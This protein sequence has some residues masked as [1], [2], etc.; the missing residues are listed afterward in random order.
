MWASSVVVVNEGLENASQMV[1]VE[2]QEMVQTLFAHGGHPPF[3][4]GIGV[5]RLEGN[6]N[7]ADT[8]LRDLEP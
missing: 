8:G 2:D 3:G 4:E 7:D 5:G 6:R 1:L